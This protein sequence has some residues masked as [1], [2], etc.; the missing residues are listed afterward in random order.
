M[1]NKTHTIHTAI[2]R[3]DLRDVMLYIYYK[4]P[5]HSLKVS[6]KIPDCTLPRINEHES[7][8]SKL[9]QAPVTE[10]V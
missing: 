2:I 6:L 10:T 5:P 7:K 9:P 4:E 8:G 1:K 3:P